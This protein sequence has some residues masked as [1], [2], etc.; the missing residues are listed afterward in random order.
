MEN[1]LEKVRALIKQ[2]IDSNRA[3]AK[4]LGILGKFEA[5][6]AA[7]NRAVDYM[8]AIAKLGDEMGMSVR[9]L[10]DAITMLGMIGGI[11][12]DVMKVADYYSLAFSERML[13]DKP[14]SEIA[15]LFR[16]KSANA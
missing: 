9:Q 12:P 3:R 14:T 8:V 5:G 2:K 13:K 15:G 16:Q 1:E 11:S 10:Q 4:E 6:L 7:M